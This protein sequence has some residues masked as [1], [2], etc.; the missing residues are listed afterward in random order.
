MKGIGIFL[1]LA[2]VWLGGFAF[3]HHAGKQENTK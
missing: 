1:I 2:L 3:G